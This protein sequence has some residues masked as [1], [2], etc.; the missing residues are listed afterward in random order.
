[1]AGERAEPGLDPVH[2]LD[3]TREVAALDDLLD[4]TQ[5]F[6]RKA[7]VL[8][9]DRHGRSDIGLPDMIG[10]EFLQSRIGIS[11]LVRRVAVEQR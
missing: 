6:S 1:M 5:L 10:A 4:Q 11:S 9:P 2:A 8:V 3:Y 7:C